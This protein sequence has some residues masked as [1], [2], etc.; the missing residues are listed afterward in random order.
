MQIASPAAPS[1]S[2]ARCA[3]GSARRRARRPRR[4]RARG[5]H[6]T[7]RS[8]RLGR[9]PRP[10]VAE[11]E[12]LDPALGLPHQVAADEQ[13]DADAERGVERMQ[14]LAPREQIVEEERDE[15]AERGDRRQDV[16]VEL[17]LDEAE[18]ND[19][20]DRPQRDH[21]ADAALARVGARAQN[22][23]RE[24]RRQQRGPQP[25]AVADLARVVLERAGRVVDAAGG[26]VEDVRE[27]VLVDEAHALLE[28]HA[29]V[30][31]QHDDQR[32]SGGRA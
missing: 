20:R 16:V 27:Q 8:P 12:H 10:V 9:R 7:D 21:E 25:H 14:A 32:S 3:P 31:R 19:R 29:D 15:D 5:S 11:H 6:R 22:A 17:G 1:A 4:C 30:P 18:T 23:R 13:H 24:R 26:A 2:D 28:V